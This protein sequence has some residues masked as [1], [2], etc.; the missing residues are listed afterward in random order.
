MIGVIMILVG[1]AGILLGTFCPGLF[2]PMSGVVSASILDPSNIIIGS[3]FVKGI[4]WLLVYADGTTKKVKDGT[5]D[6]TKDDD[7]KS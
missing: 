2:A 3:I 1:T 7:K 6:V 5:H 4:G